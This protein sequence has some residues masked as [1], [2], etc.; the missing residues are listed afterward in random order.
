MSKLER[1]NPLINVLRKNID[2]LIFYHTIYQFNTTFMFQKNIED[3]E[4]F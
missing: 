4:E 1:E 3:I 2:H